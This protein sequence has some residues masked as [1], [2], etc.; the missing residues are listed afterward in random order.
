MERIPADRPVKIFGASS[1][2]MYFYW[3]KSY[4]FVNYLDQSTWP[5]RPKRAVIRYKAGQENQE[6][7]IKKNWRLFGLL[8][9]DF[10]CCTSMYNMFS[11]LCERN[12][13]RAFLPSYFVDCRECFGLE[14]FDDCLSPLLL[15]S[16]EFTRKA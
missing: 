15:S 9:D 13:M 2:N 16:T 6:Y 7:G 3:Q 5:N 1:L 8:N 11:T 12:I 14:T 10:S 4:L